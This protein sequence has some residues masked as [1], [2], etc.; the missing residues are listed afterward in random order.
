KA[1]KE[2]P[3][4]D[5]IIDQTLE[6]L[7]LKKDVI[8]NKFGDILILIDDKATE[9]YI[10]YEKKALYKLAEEW[11]KI[12]KEDIK[13]ELENILSQKNWENFIKEASKVFTEFG[14]LVQKF[15]KDLGNMRKARGGITFQKTVLKLL[16]FIGIKGEIPYG[17]EGESLGR[18]DIVIPSSEI[19]LK[20]PD[21]AVFLTCKRTLRERWKQETPLLKYSKK[22]FL[23][24]IDENIS[25]KK[26]YEINKLGFI[27]FIKDDIKTDKFSSLEWIRSLNDLPK[28]ILSHV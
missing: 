12:Q 6:D 7:K 9:I 17:K 14:I 1:K 8:F 15:E 25:E 22:I 16:N 23:V 28:E 10:Y 26:A 11:I 27:A 5:K 21:K 18:V 24:T 20:F 4:V 19:A 13:R 2:I 3:L